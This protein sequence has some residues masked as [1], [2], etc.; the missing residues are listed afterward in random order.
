MKSITS[1]ALCLLLKKMTVAT[2]ISD[3]ELTV[4]NTNHLYAFLWHAYLFAAINQLP[5]PLTS[6]IFCTSV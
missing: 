4:T 6:V 5:V 3:I 2:N 1:S